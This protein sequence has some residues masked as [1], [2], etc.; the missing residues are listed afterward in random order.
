MCVCAESL[1]LRWL[2]LVVMTLWAQRRVGKMLLGKLS[3]HV[4]VAAD[5]LQAFEV[6]EWLVGLL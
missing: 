3:L 2:L 1:L 6:A 5:G 4:D